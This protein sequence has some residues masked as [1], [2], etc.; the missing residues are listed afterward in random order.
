METFEKMEKW[1][2]ER[3]RGFLYKYYCENDLK[4]YL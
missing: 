3:F 4:K 2:M 1:K